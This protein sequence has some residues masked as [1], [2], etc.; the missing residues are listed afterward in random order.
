MNGNLNTELYNCYIL[1]FDS[2]F[3]HVASIGL[4]FLCSNVVTSSLQYVKWY[5]PKYQLYK[6]I[7][8]YYT[9]L[10]IKIS[11]VISIFFFIRFA[12]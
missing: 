12:S 1:V 4:S 5:R 9:G 10:L 6:D 7:S 8:Y 3:T 2:R 11:C